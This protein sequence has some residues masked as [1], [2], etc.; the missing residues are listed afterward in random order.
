MTLQIELTSLLEQRLTR[1]A[2]RRGM[3]VETLTLAL[4]DEHL[5]APD[6]QT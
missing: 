5:P 2:D 3:P 4:L 6:R 1:E